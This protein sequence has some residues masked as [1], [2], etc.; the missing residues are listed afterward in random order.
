MFQQASSAALYK[1]NSPF[2][3]M[4]QFSTSW[5]KGLD[6][7]VREILVGCPLTF[8]LGYNCI[9]F[10]HLPAVPVTKQYP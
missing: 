7:C 3:F 2:K 4:R 1:S 8:S 10:S 5:A 9:F 6:A